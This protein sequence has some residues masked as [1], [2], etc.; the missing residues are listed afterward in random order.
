MSSPKLKHCFTLCAALLIVVTTEA[1]A[2]VVEIVGSRALGMGGAFV[3]VASD[4]SATWWNPAGLATGPFLDLALARA[5][6]ETTG[7]LPAHRGEARWFAFGTP[8][9]GV[10]YY[11]LKITDVQPL[12]PTVT[13]GGS[14]EDRRAG[15][16]TIAAS[17]LG[18]TLVHTLIPGLHAGATL[19]YLRATVRAS[20]D[21]GL[22]AAGEL[23]DRG[24]EL[25]GGDAGSAFDADIGLMGVAGAFRVGAVVRNAR[26]VEFEHEG[27]VTRMERQIRVGAAYDGATIGRPPLTIAV[28]AD[29]R[30]TRR[31][32]GER[33]NVAVGAEQWLKDQRIGIRAGARFNTVGAKER[34]ATGGVSVAVR[35]GLFLDAHLVRGGAEDDRG[36]GVA[37][38]VS[39]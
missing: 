36:W 12:T 32:F 3:A 9:I 26:E 38:R 6:T 5:M 8:A 21:D 27:G 20:H 34:T 35:S 16:Q 7:D 1:R 29:L 24:E 18:I 2:Q 25:D 22:L 11:R 31:A 30:S 23:L 28:D 13:E 14:R 37:A 19:K 17:Q 10:S 15:L 33:R 39:F 4:S